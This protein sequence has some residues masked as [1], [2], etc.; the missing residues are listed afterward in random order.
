MQRRKFLLG[1]ASTAIGASAVVGSGAFTAA[2]VSNRDVAVTVTDDSESLLA[3]RSGNNYDPA[4]VTEESGELGIDLGYSDNSVS[5][6]TAAGVNPN[7]T[8]QIGDMPEPEDQ[9]ALEVGDPDEDDDTETIEPL[10]QGDN[11]ASDHAFSIVNQSPSTQDVEVEVNMEDVPDNISLYFVG[12]V[13][14]VG[15]GEGGAPPEDALVAGAAIPNNNW[16]TVLS[17]TSDSSGNVKAGNQIYISILVD[18][19]DLDE[20]NED[21]TDWTGTMSVSAGKSDDILDD[22]ELTDGTDNTDTEDIPDDTA[23]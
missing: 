19:G 11:M 9:P 22:G 17:F 4:Y 23:Q 2:E 16:N 15:E 3:L 7:S 14:G 18:R 6:D 8:Y 1:A 13:S 12:R 5:Q 21:D 20:G 10:S